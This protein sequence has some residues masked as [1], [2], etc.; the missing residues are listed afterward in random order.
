MDHFRPSDGEWKRRSGGVR[1]QRSLRRRENWLRRRIIGKDKIHLL[2]CSISPK[3]LWNQTDLC[4]IGF[5]SIERPSAHKASPLLGEKPFGALDSNK[6]CYL[7]KL[8]IEC[9]YAPN[10]AHDAFRQ[11]HHMVAPKITPNPGTFRKCTTHPA[12]ICPGKGFTWNLR[13]RKEA[14][15][16]CINKS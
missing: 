5:L 2:P 9:I 3:A 10:V 14:G 11:E 15:H 16:A 1:L 13:L 4:Q 8:P 12:A 6:P 7:R